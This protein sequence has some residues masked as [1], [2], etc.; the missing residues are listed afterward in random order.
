MT[1]IIY[2]ILANNFLV[3]KPVKQTVKQKTLKTFKNLETFKNF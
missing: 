2:V 1:Y 3:I